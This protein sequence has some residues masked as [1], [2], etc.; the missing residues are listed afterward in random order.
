M[1]L[2]LIVF[3]LLRCVQAVP[4]VA[5]YQRLYNVISQD[6]VFNPKKI[7]ALVRSSFHDVMNYDSDRNPHVGNGCIFT[8]NQTQNEQL[9]GPVADLYNLV[10]QNLPDQRQER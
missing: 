9:V 2:I 5:D 8:Q 6:L 7:P 3:E 4:T 10:K 1:V